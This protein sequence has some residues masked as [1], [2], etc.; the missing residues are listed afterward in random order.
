MSGSESVQEGEW[1]NERERRMNQEASGG[2]DEWVAVG[3]GVN[4]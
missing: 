4:N 2:K 3:G 1:I